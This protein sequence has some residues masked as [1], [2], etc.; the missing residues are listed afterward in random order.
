MILR[1]TDKN[2]NSSS[3]LWKSPPRVIA[4]FQSSPNESVK[5][6]SH[7]TYVS[8]RSSSTKKILVPRCQQLDQ[9]FSIPRHRSAQ[10]LPLSPQ[11]HSKSGTMATFMVSKTQQKKERIEFLSH[12]LN[13]DYYDDS[14]EAKK[15][16]NTKV[17][18]RDKPQS[19]AAFIQQNEKQ[20]QKAMEYGSPL[21]HRQTERVLQQ[22]SSKVVSI[23]KDGF[24]THSHR[25][26]S[27]KTMA[28]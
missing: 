15:E 11:I 6:S 10:K 23:E 20:S 14:L 21:T 9:F 17:A 8:E 12:R 19:S 25:M 27:P 5:K 28:I 3:N 1:A 18:V 16:L 24:E 26:R 7:S 13:Q 2:T 22:R 4:P